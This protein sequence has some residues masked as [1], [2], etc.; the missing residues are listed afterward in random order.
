MLAVCAA[1]RWEVQ[2]VLRALGPVRRLRRDG[3]T[4]WLSRDVRLPVLVFRTGIGQERAAAATARVLDTFPAVRAVINAGCAGAL[5]PTLAPGAVVIPPVVYDAADPEMPSFAAN[6][7]WAARLQRAAVR[8]GLT[9]N[10]GPIHST[11]RPLTNEA[12]KRAAHEVRGATAAEM[13]GAAVAA[14][15]QRRGIDFA[16]VR[17][18]LDDV[19]TGVPD[20]A[21][22]EN[23]NT[24]GLIARFKLY[25]GSVA[26]VADLTPLFTLP[27]GVRAVRTALYGVFHMLFEGRPV[28]EDWF[29]IDR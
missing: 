28:I 15:A 13:E 18:I 3:A 21:P 27:G 2:P 14:V 16:A 1:M 9:P 4:A 20:L 25:L 10:G 6:P 8:A 23:E 5:I 29:E 19:A 24:D 11:S 26:H 17:S 7:R 12:S 22:G